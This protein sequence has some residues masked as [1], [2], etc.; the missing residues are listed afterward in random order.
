[1]KQNTFLGATLALTWLM[2]AGI[3]AHEIEHGHEHVEGGWNAEAGFVSDVDIKAKL[4]NQRGKSVDEIRERAKFV[5]ETSDP[6]RTPEELA[7]DK[8]LQAKYADAIVINSLMPGL[9]GVQGAQKVHVVDG[10]NSNYEAN[11]DLVSGSIWAYPGVNDISVEDTVERTDAILKEMGVEKASSVEQVRAAAAKD[12]PLAM[13][14]SQGADFLADDMERIVWM[15]EQGVTVMAFTYNLDNPLSGGGQNPEDNG[16]TELGIEF[17]KRANELGIVVDCSHASDQ[18]CI[19]A[20]KYSTKPILATHS[21][22]KGVFDNLRNVSDDAIKAIAESGGAV[23]PLGAGLFL[24]PEGTASMEDIAV[25]VEYIGNLVGRDHTCYGSDKLHHY[26]DMLMAAIPNVEL[27]PPE[28][29]FGAP[30]EAATGADIWGI[31]AV[32]ED[33]YGWS[34]KDIRGFLGENLMRVY[35]ANW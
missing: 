31:V 18:T 14:N 29:G 20:A 21:N 35:E 1:M 3:M 26:F 4:W 19:D 7:R 10:L 25:H 34:E 15:K 13:Y 32:L 9:A 33:K 17:I 8:E 11:V 22:A 16:V 12:Q 28:R 30:M 2:P 6:P 23:C 27:Y 24:N 5:A